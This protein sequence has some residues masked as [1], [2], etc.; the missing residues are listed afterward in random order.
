M[1]FLPHSRSGKLEGADLCFKVDSG[2][3]MVSGE[4]I[5]LDAE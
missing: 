2:C 5:A 1:K 3:C 4:V